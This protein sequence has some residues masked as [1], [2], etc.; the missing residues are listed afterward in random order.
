MTRPSNEEFWTVPDVDR[1]TLDELFT[2]LE[3]EA[4]RQKFRKAIK[5]SVDR[6]YKARY[7]S[8]F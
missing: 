8:E 5:K 7:G 6:I 2:P 4:K 3:I 1:L